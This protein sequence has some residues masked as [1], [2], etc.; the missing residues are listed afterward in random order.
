MSMENLE[1]RGLAGEN[2]VLGEK[3]PHFGHHKSHMTT[4]ARTRAAA[5]E[6]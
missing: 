2:E 4:W 1:E 6:S 3:L 5:V